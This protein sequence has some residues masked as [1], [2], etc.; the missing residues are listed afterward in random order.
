MP[1]KTEACRQDSCSLGSADA[2]VHACASLHAYKMSNDATAGNPSATVLSL[3]GAVLAKVPYCQKAPTQKVIRGT[4]ICAHS[5]ACTLR[6]MHTPEHAQQRITHFLAQVMFFAHIEQIPK[7]KSATAV[8]ISHA[9]HML[10]S[11][12]FGFSVIT[13]HR[14][15]QSNCKLSPAS[16]V[17]GP[18][19]VAADKGHGDDKRHGS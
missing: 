16:C 14:V 18:A 13:L 10:C 19:F 3:F 1:N 9:S 4:Y 5:G 2:Y 17:Y 7:K 11:H 12:L 8:G 6:S 15:K